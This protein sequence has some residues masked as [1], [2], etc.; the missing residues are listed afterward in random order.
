MEQAWRRMALTVQVAT[1]LNRSHLINGKTAYLLPC[2]SRIERDVQATGP[3]TVSMEDSTSCIHA[4]FGDKT[5]AGDKLKSEPAIIAGIAKALL[6]P[7]P[8]VDWDAWVGDYG[9]VREAIEATYPQWFRDFNARFRQPGGFYRGNKARNR[10]F[11]ES[12]SG[13]ANFVRP[14]A[15]SA[16]GF[17][18]QDGV[19]RLMTLR[20]NDQF[21]T[22]IYG[23]DDRMRG[24]SGSRDVLF[25]NHHDMQRLGLTQ[26]QVVGLA[27]VS[28]DNVMRQHHG[29]QVV[30]YEIPQGCLGAYY[31]ECN[32]LIPLGHYARES[33]TP[34]VKTV[35]VRILL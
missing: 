29:L 11:T 24:V 35:P 5:P 8:K 9:L 2:L 12:A 6:P 18:E 33:Y 32:D 20:S 1:K 30:P 21:N 23:Y 16:T 27:T 25:V 7:N 3:Q 28:N 31:P 14:T 15:L 26:G 4:S 19:F 17:E 13:K 22:T 10:D 34:A